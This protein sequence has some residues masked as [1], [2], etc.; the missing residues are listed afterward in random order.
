MPN[1]NKNKKNQ[2]FISSTEDQIADMFFHPTEEKEDDNH[3]IGTSMTEME[4][5]QANFSQ[6][7]KQLDNLEPDSKEPSKTELPT[8]EKKDIFDQDNNWGDEKLSKVTRKT[9]PEIKNS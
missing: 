7:E 2:D 9:H 8:K 1:T 3:D 6:I 4:D 5:A